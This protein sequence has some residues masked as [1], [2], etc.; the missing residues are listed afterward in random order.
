[1]ASK[2]SD[3]D[4]EQAAFIATLTREAGLMNAALETLEG[5]YI[6]NLGS[7]LDA[8]EDYVIAQI[9]ANLN[10]GRLTDPSG[11]IKAANRLTE[12][13]ATR[14]FSKVVNEYLERTAQEWLDETINFGKKI[15]KSLYTEEYL[16][17]IERLPSL[18]YAEILDLQSTIMNVSTRA[19]LEGVD[20]MPPK[21]KRQTTLGMLA[22]YD[23]ILSK[24]LPRDKRTEFAVAKE[25]R[26][27]VVGYIARNLKSRKEAIL[28]AEMPKALF[29]DTLNAFPALAMQKSLWDLGMR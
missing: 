7:Q 26:P 19:F 17:R 27:E 14:D 15:I 1:M 29:E 23:W 16:D 2:Y 5:L 6:P 22:D 12:L 25:N 21:D 9:N 24:A 3:E 18:S 8:V 11:D 10:S 4:R 20:A 13:E 28:A